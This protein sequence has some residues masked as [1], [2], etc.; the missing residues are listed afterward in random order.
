ME[1]ERDDSNTATT[2]RYRSTGL[3]GMLLSAVKSLSKDDSTDSA[4]LKLLPSTSSA[5]KEEENN[6]MNEVEEKE[7]QLGEAP[8]PIVW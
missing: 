6:E 7:H 2:L 1:E 3:A 5:N 4:E 8:K